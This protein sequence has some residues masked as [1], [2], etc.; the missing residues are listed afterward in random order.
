MDYPEKEV[1][2][3]TD[4]NKFVN[5]MCGKL[6]FCMYKRSLRYFSSTL[7]KMG[8]KKCCIHCF[9]ECYFHYISWKLLWSSHTVYVENMLITVWKT[10]SQVTHLSLHGPFSSERHTTLD[11]LKSHK[12]NDVCVPWQRGEYGKRY[13]SSGMIFIFCLAIASKKRHLSMKDH[14]YP[15]SLAFNEAQCRNGVRE[16]AHNRVVCPSREKDVISGRRMKCV[17]V[18]FS[19][20]SVADL[21]PSSR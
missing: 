5:K 20:C 13:L 10:S 21:I 7:W 6:T 12:R 3:I 17:S 9:D 11:W 19:K 4:F 2:T 8:G 16:T 1:V 15:T 18:S 14:I